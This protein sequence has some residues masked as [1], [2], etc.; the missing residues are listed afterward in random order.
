M[1]RESRWRRWSENKFVEFNAVN[2]ISS[3]SYLTALSL[4]QSTFYLFQIGFRQSIDHVYLSRGLQWSR[5]DRM[6]LSLSLSLIRW[7]MSPRMR[8]H[9]LLSTLSRCFLSREFIH[10]WS[11]S[12]AVILPC[13]RISR[14]RMWWEWRWESRE[15]SDCRWRT[16]SFGWNGDTVTEKP[17]TSTL[18]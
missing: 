7:I 2:Q 8:L 10:L 9:R 4:L 17:W 15:W 1:W 18:N 14:T 16:T 13:D 5:G 6:F 11:K 12:A 3:Y